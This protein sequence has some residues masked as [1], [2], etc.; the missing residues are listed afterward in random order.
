MST[1]KDALQRD[2]EYIQ[3]IQKLQQ[4]GFFKGELHGSATWNDLEAK[5]ALQFSEGRQA[6]F[7][8]F[9]FT[10]T[11]LLTPYYSNAGRLSFASLVDKAISDAQ[12][13]KIHDFAE[14]EEE[15]DEWLTITESM[16]DDIFNRTQNLSP[17][18]GAD[19]MDID[20]EE[21]KKL[22]DTKTR[23]QAIKLQELAKKVEKFVE[24]QGDVEGATFE[25]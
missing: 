17:P 1:R 20:V 22:E 14:G 8:F 9:L 11:I 12:Q 10:K 4:V 7:V 19:K 5:A 3:Y 18:E 15:S 13:E 16:M 25:E 21:A 24:G 6:E 23:Q 2:P